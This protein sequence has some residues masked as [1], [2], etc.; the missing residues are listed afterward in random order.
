M[1]KANPFNHLIKTLEIGGKKYQY[2]SLKE[3]KDDR[4]G[5]KKFFFSKK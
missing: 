5:K 3:L 2:Y 4:L 1:E